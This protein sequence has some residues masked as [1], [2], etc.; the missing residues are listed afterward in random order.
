[1]LQFLVGLPWFIMGLDNLQILHSCNGVYKEFK[2]S[3]RIERG[4]R[5]CPICLL[6]DQLQV[7]KSLQQRVIIPHRIVS[8]TT[9]IHHAFVRGS[10]EDAMLA[11]DALVGRFPFGIQFRY[12]TARVCVGCGHV[13]SREF[14]M[15]SLDIEVPVYND[16]EKSVELAQMVFKHFQEDLVKD[17]KCATFVLFLLLVHFPQTF[18]HTE[19]CKISDGEANCV[20][21]MLSY[22]KQLILRLKRF[23]DKCQK[24]NTKMKLSETI[25]IGNDSAVY[26]YRL[27]SAVLHE[28]KTIYG[29]HYM[30]LRSFKKVWF[31]FDDEV[32]MVLSVFSQ[33][34]TCCGRR[35]H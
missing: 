25:F 29:G 19:R 33:H 1:V 14:N 13:N 28:G 8:H 2:K 15:W 3:T 7:V 6:Y 17:Y 10:Q 24:I 35:L 18:Q 5:L 32:C 30:A 22:P 34:A 31:L 21:R 11:L 12:Q 20:Y 4:Y 26:E 23:N 16:P 9:L 27:Q